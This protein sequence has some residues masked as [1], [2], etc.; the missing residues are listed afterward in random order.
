MNIWELRSENNYLKK[1]VEELQ[2]KITE[3]TD[4]NETLKIL[5][6]T[7]PLTK[8]H[9]RKW[10]MDLFR[11]EYKRTR[12]DNAKLSVAVI[13]IDNF[14]NIN[15]TY[16]HQT[17]DA[18]LAEIGRIIKERIRETDRAGRFGGEEFI[19]LL[20]N[21][22]NEGAT[23]VAENI[24]AE[25]ERSNPSGIHVTISAG[26]VAYDS[27]SKLT[28]EEVFKKADDALYASKRGGKNKITIAKAS[29]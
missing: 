19:I 6:I 25:V 15:D 12:R 3:L 17:G 4:E 16:G 13:D 27:A 5:T 10:I 2:T 22:N 14:K 7:D 9:N 11:Q 24:R 23:K 8:L 1:V 20:P 28:M 18:V 29:E 26:I 21:T